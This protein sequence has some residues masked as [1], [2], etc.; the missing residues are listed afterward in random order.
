MESYYCITSRLVFY[1]D[2]IFDGLIL[3]GHVLQHHH[4]LDHVVSFQLLPGSSALEPVSSQRKQYRYRHQTTAQRV[5]TY[6]PKVADILSF[7]T[8][9]DPV[10]AFCYLLI[11]PPQ[12]LW[13][14]VL[15]A[16]LS[17]TSGTGRR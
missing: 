14:S 10:F 8:V 1:R 11:C 15:A 2:C 7:P 17:T 12:V 5:L 3:G 6:R 9:Y 4:G 16:A 13:R